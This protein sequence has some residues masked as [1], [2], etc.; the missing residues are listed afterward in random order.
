LFLEG[1]SSFTCTIPSASCGRG[2]DENETHQ[3]Q[4]QQ[5][6]Q[7]CAAGAAGDGASGIDESG[8]PPGERED[9]GMADE[10]FAD[11][12]SVDVLPVA[13]VQVAEDSTSIRTVCVR[14]MVHQ[15]TLDLVEDLVTT[16]NS[17]ATDWFTLKCD[18]K[19]RRYAK[20]DQQSL[21]A[22][23]EA[24]KLEDEDE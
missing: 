7:A 19:L 12:K 18:S 15:A 20:E 22:A 4:T 24:S 23:M 6:P 9:E 11:L 21:R 3:R 2:E 1:T 17:L 16:A 8:T 14:A 13:E 10:L 5:A